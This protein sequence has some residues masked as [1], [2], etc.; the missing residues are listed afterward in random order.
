MTWLCQCRYPS[1]VI[2]IFLLWVP[3]Q[4]HPYHCSGGESN[5]TAV[6]VVAVI[7]VEVA[8][9]VAAVEVAVEEAEL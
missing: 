6:I 7:A 4:S 9:A 2:S 8:I 1:M 5:C 3:E